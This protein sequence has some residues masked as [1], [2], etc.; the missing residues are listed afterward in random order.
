[1]SKINK[2]KIKK[3]DPLDKRLS[4]AGFSGGAGKSLTAKQNKARLEKLRKKEAPAR[5]R[6]ER[7]KDNKESKR[8]DAQE[9]KASEIFKKLTGTEKFTAKKL[10]INTKNKNPTTVRNAIE[11]KIGDRMFSDRASSYEPRFKKKGGVI[12]KSRGGM[13]NGN[14]L[15]SSYYEKG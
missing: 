10:G 5:K 12:K 15:V 6:L 4:D 14:D 8:D 3:I 7:I 2:N 9:P 13:I 1:M 11:N